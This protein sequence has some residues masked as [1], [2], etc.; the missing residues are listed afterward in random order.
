MR[1][2]AAISTTRALVIALAWP[3][4]IV[5]IPAVLSLVVANSDLLT[6]GRIHTESGSS[7]VVPGTR[8]ID[9]VLLVGPPLIFLASWAL[10]RRVATR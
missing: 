8:W 4:V 9:L 3:A 10:A 2:L 7:I 5:G 6:A 1:S